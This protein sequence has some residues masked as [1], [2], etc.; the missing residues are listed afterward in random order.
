MQD[1]KCNCFIRHALTEE[2]RKAATDR[3]EYSRS[4]KDNLGVLV[5]MAALAGCPPHTY[6]SR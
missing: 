2:E 5:A 4:I 1:K 3:L 6:V